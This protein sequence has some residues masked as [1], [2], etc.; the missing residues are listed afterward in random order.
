MTKREIKR[1]EN[2]IYRAIDAID[3]LRDIGFGCDETERAL[4]LLRSVQS[5]V[6]DAVARADV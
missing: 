4:E 1:A 3:L 5:R 2:A 6:N